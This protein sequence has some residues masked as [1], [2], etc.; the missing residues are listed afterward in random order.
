MSAHEAWAIHTL[1]ARWKAEAGTWGPDERA[2]HARHLKAL[3]APLGPAVVEVV[4]DEEPHPKWQD[5]GVCREPLPN[6]TALRARATVRAFVRVDT[7]EDEA[8][9][10]RF[11]A[12]VATLTEALWGGDRSVGPAFVTQL[13]LLGPE[14]GLVA[15]GKSVPPE[16]PGGAT[17]VRVVFVTPDGRRFGPGGGR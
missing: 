16:C 14:R 9:G 4:V 8:A 7:A 3:F 5:H 10:R 13:T 11:G 6:I 2:D 1:E 17:L 15:M 12:A